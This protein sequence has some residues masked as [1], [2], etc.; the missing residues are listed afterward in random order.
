M[1]Y[2]VP[3]DDK[4]D[5]SLMRLNKSFSKKAIQQLE[6]VPD[7][8]LLISLSGTPF[9]SPSIQVDVIIVVLQI[10]LFKSMI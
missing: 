3:K 5:V 4:P 9:T 6:I 2:I 8:Q 1:Y 7:H 10:I